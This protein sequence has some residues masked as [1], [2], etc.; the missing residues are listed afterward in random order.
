MSGF[1]YISLPNYISIL[2][3]V[4]KYSYC[5]TNF[6]SHNVLFVIFFRK[7]YVSG[8]YAFYK[9]ILKREFLMKGSKYHE[10]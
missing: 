2:N 10:I 6:G 7:S 5:V 8:E 4:L 9:N 3:F 1:V